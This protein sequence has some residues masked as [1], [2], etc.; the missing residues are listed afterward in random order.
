MLAG[1]ILAIIKRD[2]VVNRERLI[3]TNMTTVPN[4]FLVRSLTSC[5]TMCLGFKSYTCIVHK[6]NI[7]LVQQNQ[8]KIHLEYG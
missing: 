2:R 1:K 7:K 6:N 8:A 5:Y 3:G 4:I